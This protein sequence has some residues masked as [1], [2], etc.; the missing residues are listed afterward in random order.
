[1][2]CDQRRDH[3]CIGRDRRGDAQVVLGA[4]V[5]MVVDVAVQR[6]DD[7][8]RTC[9]TGLFEFERVQRVRVRLADDADARPAGVTEDRDLG[10][11]RLQRSTEQRVGNERPAQCR[12]VVAQLADLCSCLVDERQTPTRAHDGAGLEERIGPAFGDQ[13][14][15]RC[16][17][18]VVAPDEDME[19]RRVASSHF[20]A[21]DRRER[22]LDG[23]VATQR[24]NRRVTPGEHLDLTCGAQPVVS[25]RPQGVLEVDQSG[26]GP[27]EVFCVEPV[28]VRVEPAFD[29]RRRGVQLI[30][31]GGDRSD[32]V[33]VAH[34]RQH[35]GQT[36]ECLVD[37]PG[38][39]CRRDDIDGGRGDRRNRQVQP[40]GEFASGGRRSRR[41]S[42][43]DADDAAHGAPGYC[44]YRPTFPAPARAPDDERNARMGR[45]S[46]VAQVSARRC[47]ASASSAATSSA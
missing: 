47:A 35:T 22:L 28:G 37:R 44:R 36:P 10:R 41:W 18:D 45:R 16:G 25:D 20:E 13:R 42:T 26:V 46:L 33:D 3:L 23:E 1:V 14:V 7:V 19:A 38:M 8:R 24:R 5:G 30:E 2:A 32:H 6:S 34:Q 11:R 29:L 31:A 4:Q 40:G 21:V 15:E 27:L 39:R 17:I 12:G 9:T 43:D